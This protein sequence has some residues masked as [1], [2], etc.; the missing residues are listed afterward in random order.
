MELRKPDGVGRE[1]KIVP[2]TLGKFS[3]PAILLDER[4]NVYVAI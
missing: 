2:P 4:G 1:L 3:K